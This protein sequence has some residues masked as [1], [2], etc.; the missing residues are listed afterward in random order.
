MTN[1]IKSETLVLSR[2]QRR[3]YED[4]KKKDTEN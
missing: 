2:E 4:T 1:C 3:N